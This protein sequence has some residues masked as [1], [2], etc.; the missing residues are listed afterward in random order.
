[1]VKFPELLPDSVIERAMKLD[2]SQLCDGMK[3]LKVPFSGCM[4]AVISPVDPSFKVCG[5]AVTVE[6]IAGDN[7]P[8]HVAT[9]TAPAA[10]Y[11]MVID[12]K[13]YEKCAYI[14]DKIMG[15]CK[16]IGYKGIVI[17]G[18]S[19]DRSGNIALEFP[20]YSRGLMPAGPVKDKMGKINDSIHCGRILVNPGDLVCG[21]DD[22][23]CVVP[24]DMIE[25]VLKAAEEKQAYENNRDIE[26]ADYM[27]KKK[28]GEPLPRLAPKWMD[29]FM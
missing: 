14:G 18:Y 20:V 10:G 3:K 19:R 25:D 12:G 24:R 23:V 1:M 4:E 17:D 26:I 7:L 8:I 15:A 9:Y 2:V 13:K 16:A 11:V 29:E 21:D 22:G 6:T 28:N 5:T 27:Q